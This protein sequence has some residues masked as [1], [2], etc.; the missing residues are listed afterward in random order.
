MFANFCSNLGSECMILVPL[1]SVLY[2]L[3]LASFVIAAYFGFRLIRLTHKT[4][5]ML[6]ISRDG[7]TTIVYGLILLAASQVPNLFATA[8]GD[9][10]S[11][12]SDILAVPV[13]VL[14]V[15]SAVMFAWG[16]HRMYSIYLNEKLKL[17]M[18]NVLEDLMEKEK[19]IEKEEFQG[20][21]R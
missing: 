8:L 18:N 17:T 7:P 3:A 2:S 13:G 10:T 9:E 20:N 19:A 5:V 16:I 14:L 12:A 15:G 4:R 6:M 11:V 1:V 21:L